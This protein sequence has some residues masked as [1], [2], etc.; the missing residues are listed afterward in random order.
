VYKNKSVREKY[1]A[2]RESISSC[3]KIQADLN[4]IIFRS[5][6]N[7][8]VISETSIAIQLAENA[9]TNVTDKT[10]FRVNR[11]IP[12]SVT[13]TNRIPLQSYMALWPIIRGPSFRS[14][15]LWILIVPV[16]STIH[17][18]RAAR[19]KN[20]PICIEHSEMACLRHIGKFRYSSFTAWGAENH[21][22]IRDSFTPQIFQHL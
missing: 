17:R 4:L 6:D 19:C 8:R 7:Y 11:F 3:R 20:L 2:N 1:Y 10:S 15:S 16:G 18:A 9:M 21:L 12:I 5:F 13:S 14:G 22:I